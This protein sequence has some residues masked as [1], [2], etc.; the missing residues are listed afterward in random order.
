MSY[1]V[2]VVVSVKGKSM[3]SLVIIALHLLGDFV[4]QTDFMAQYKRKVVTVRIAHVN[5]YTIPFIL[6]ATY[7]YGWNGSLFCLSVWITHFAIDSYVFAENHPWP[8]KSF[9]IDQSLHI[10][11][12]AVFAVWLLV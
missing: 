5:V 3:E 6:W 1:R 7:R 9:V 11:S 10:L 8:P 2:S 4:L 12:L